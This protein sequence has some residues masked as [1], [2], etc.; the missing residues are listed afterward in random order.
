MGPL[1][2]NAKEDLK[3]QKGVFSD[4]LRQKPSTRTQDMYCC[5]ALTHPSDP[6][7]TSIVD[8]SSNQLDMIPYQCLTL[9][10]LVIP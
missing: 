9:H 5:T 2:E 1:C 4:D 3:G 6:K 10:E 8:P 7:C